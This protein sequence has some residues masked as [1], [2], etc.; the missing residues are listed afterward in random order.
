MLFFFLLS[1]EG[2]WAVLSLLSSHFVRSSGVEANY[3]TF[4]VVHT[5]RTIWN[6]REVATNKVGASYV[7]GFVM[8]S[9]WGVALLDGVALF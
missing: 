9:A 5:L 7:S 6:E 2:G 3:F 8:V 4:H 1:Q